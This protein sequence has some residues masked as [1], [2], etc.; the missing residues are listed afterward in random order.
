MKPET[1][2]DR[3]TL[4]LVCCAPCCAGVVE[5]MAKSKANA[6]LF[7]YNPNIF[8]RKEYEKR[9]AEVYR[10]AAHYNIRV[11]DSDYEPEEYDN[12]TQGLENEP[13]RGRRCEACFYLRLAKTAEYAAAHGYCAFTSTLGVSKHKDQ[14]QVDAQGQIASAKYGIPYLPLDTKGLSSDIIKELGIYRQNYC[15]CIYSTK[16]RT[17][18]LRS[19]RTPV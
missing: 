13:E 2:G 4:V 3:R 5:Y 11:I 9:K 6:D 14:T 12:A 10:L 16:E 17:T 1:I 8:P 19:G 7:F 18:P 15:G